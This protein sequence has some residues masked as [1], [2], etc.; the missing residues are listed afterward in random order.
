MEAAPKE[1]RGFS[2]LA[3]AALLIATGQKNSS[4][5]AVDQAE[6]LVKEVESRNHIVFEAE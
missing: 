4:K 6:M 3:I 1:A 5:D 2:I